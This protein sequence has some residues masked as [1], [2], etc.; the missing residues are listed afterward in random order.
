MRRGKHLRT[1]IIQRHVDPLHQRAFRLAEMVMP[2]EQRAEMG[3][4][5]TVLEH[6]PGE[7]LDEPGRQIADLRGAPP[8]GRSRRQGQGAG[9]RI[10][11]VV[12]EKRWGIRSQ[13]WVARLVLRLDHLT[14]GFAVQRDQGV[15]HMIHYRERIEPRQP[16]P[17]MVGRR[18][19]VIGIAQRLQGGRDRWAERREALCEIPVAF[20][21]QRDAARGLVTR[22]KDPLGHRLQR[23]NW[24]TRAWQRVPRR[25][26]AG[27][28]N[29]ANR[30]S[31]P[32]QIP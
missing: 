16:A 27:W 9:G 28:N 6:H 1:S 30:I 20:Y 17:A 10:G 7:R 21:V 5:R 18:R 11:G 2:V 14:I 8:A 22:G 25:L 19:H 23:R 31:N 3:V 29:C 4:K 32:Q 24:R 12:A 26:A 15:A 13:R